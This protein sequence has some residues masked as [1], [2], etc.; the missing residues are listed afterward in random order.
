MAGVEIRAQRWS[1]GFAHAEQGFHVVDQHAGVHFDANL[2]FVRFG[3]RGRPA[4]V[5]DSHL[6]PLVIQD[7]KEVRRPGAGHPVGL[8]ITGGS[9]RQP[10]KDIHC[11]NA[12]HFCQADGL[13]EDLIRSLGDIL[14]RSDRIPVAAETA[15]DHPSGFHRLQVGFPLF[16]AGEQF[17]HVAMVR[18]G[19][20]AGANLHRGSTVR[21]DFIQGCLKWEA[22]EK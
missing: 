16:I 18:S 13:A 5:G 19:Q 7:C 22:A 2:H 21:E 15:D 6:V 14:I 8:G 11:R 4:P 9:R 1:A 10:G 17:I 3:E 12:A 20:A